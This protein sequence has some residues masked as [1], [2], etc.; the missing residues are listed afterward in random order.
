MKR[1]IIILLSLT[2]LIS[3]ALYSCQ[4]GGDGNIKENSSADSD[5]GTADSLAD[6]TSENGES[7][8]DRNSIADN[9]PDIDYGGYT[10]NILTGNEQYYV[11]SLVASEQIGEVINDAVYIANKTVEDRFNINIK[12]TQTEGPFIMDNAKKSIK[13]GGDEYDLLFGHDYE[14]GTA[15]LEGLFLN[16][17]YLDRLDFEKPWWPNNTVESL[18]ING[19]MYLFSNSLTTLGMDW[20]RLLYINKG[21]AKDL[22][23]EVPYKDVFDGTWTLDKLTKLTKDVYID[24]NGDG[25]KDSDDKYGYA[26]TG[27][28]YCSIEP[29][30][31]QVVKK[32]GDIL[33]LNVL[34]ER[35]QKMVDMMYD[36]MI[37]SKG[38]F[39]FG[40]EEHL[41]EKIFTNGNALIIYKHLQDARKTLRA[42]DIDYGI[43]PFPKLDENQENYYAGYHDRLFAVPITASNTDR[44]AVIIEAMSAEGWKK[45]FPAYYEISMKNKFLADEESIKILDMIYSSR[46]LDF[47]YIYSIS[48]YMMLNDLFNNDK[49]ST[50]FV[51]YYEKNLGSVQ[52]T[53]DNIAKKFSEMD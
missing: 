51:S 52:K 30:G 2:L 44:S 25:V 48:Y 45:V 12:V 15:S 42:S 32:S 29:F 22:G 28:Y 49:P 41:S 24:V 16:L 34:G 53:L 8:G 37:N 21:L 27:S 5:N 7:P 19:K 14:S 13:S 23:L 43:L 47:T 35:T 36:L 46:V 10:F 9:L 11:D 31:I 38:T 1:T 17:Y 39:Y 20:T 4:K 26:F 40:P 33:E 50:D 3:F 6:D 18:T